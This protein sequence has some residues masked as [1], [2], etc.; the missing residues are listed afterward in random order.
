M[1]AAQRALACCR[2]LHRENS[3]EAGS[4]KGV[5]APRP[6]W[7]CHFTKADGAFAHN[8]RRPLLRLCLGRQ[9]ASARRRHPRAPFCRREVSWT[10]R[11]IGTFIQLYHAKYPNPVAAPGSRGALS[12]ETG[13][14]QTKQSALRAV[15]IASGQS[16]VNAGRAHRLGRL[17]S[18]FIRIRRR[19]VPGAISCVCCPANR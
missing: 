6:A 17:A 3:R 5:I 16:P 12:S 13:C 8:C 4:A 10:V 19:R 11:N 18:R 9:M 7:I 15:R 2:S 1:L 14:A